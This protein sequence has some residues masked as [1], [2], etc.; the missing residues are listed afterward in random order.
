MMIDPCIPSEAQEQAAFVQYVRIK[1]PD[2]LIFAIPN[3]GSRNKA[4]AS[5]MK[6]GGVVAGIPDLFVPKFRLWIEMKR[7]KG[8]TVSAKQKEIMHQLE[9]VGYVCRVCRGADEA[10]ALMEEVIG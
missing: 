3:G 7:R 5:R 8:G 10:I 2:I 9:L 1:H 4:E 6:A